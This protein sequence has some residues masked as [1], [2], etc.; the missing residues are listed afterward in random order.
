M[1]IV[2][3]SDDTALAT[4]Q[5]DLHRRRRGALN[6]FFSKESIRKLDPVLQKNLRKLLKRL[7]ERKKTGES[8]N[9]M[10]IYS[11]F[12]A[13]IITEYAF[14]ESSD[15]LEQQDFNAPFY[16]IMTTVH[17]LHAPA[18]QFPFLMTMLDTIPE[19]LLAKMNEGARYSAQWKDVS[20]GIHLGKVHV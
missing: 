8:F 2:G 13:D 12:T 10:L 7:E 4:V 9:A 5:H 18:K 20:R 3:G 14:G 16:Q 19:K 15:W 6:P 17:E 1:R 11:A